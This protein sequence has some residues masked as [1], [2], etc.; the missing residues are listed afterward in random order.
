L[1]KALLGTHAVFLLVQELLTTVLTYHVVP[2]AAVMAADLVDGD[3][4]QSM[5]AGP[6]GELTVGAG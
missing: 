3:L 2:G 6:T 4:F 1:T 5:L